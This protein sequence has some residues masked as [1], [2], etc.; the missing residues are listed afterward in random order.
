MPLGFVPGLSE[1]GYMHA[2]ECVSGGG[3]WGRGRR[4]RARRLRLLVWRLSPY[5]CRWTNG[6]LPTPSGLT[7]KSFSSRQQRDYRR[8]ILIYFCEFTYAK[9]L[10]HKPWHQLNL[11]E[12]KDISDIV[13]FIIRSCTFCSFCLMCRGKKENPAAPI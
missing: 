2:C 11:I 5:R 12:Q 3:W 9:C 4:S 1:G 13:Y 8:N 7:H 6:K 10:P